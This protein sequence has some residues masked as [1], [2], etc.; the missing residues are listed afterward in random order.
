MWPFTKRSA[1]KRGPAGSR[2][3]RKAEKAHV[4]HVVG[5][6]SVGERAVPLV[7][8]QSRRARRVALNIDPVEDA[9]E[10]VLPRGVPLN[11]GLRFAEQK[12][13]WI[14][15]RL[16]LRPPKVAFEPGAVIPY[17]GIDHVIEHRPD[18]RAGVWRAESRVCVSGHA[19]FTS[20]RVQD[21][22][23]A[24]ALRELT[25]RS[26]EKAAQLG[27][28]VKH[29]HLRDPKG[30]WGSC[31]PD[32]AINYS[33]RLILAPELVLDYVV[34]HEVAH[35]IHNNH[36]VRF[37]RLVARLTPEM[38]ASRDWLSHH[39]DRLMRYG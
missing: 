36:G 16:A 33:W 10:L 4:P 27:R 37:W 29:V 25:E 7:A 22:L 28:R 3:A 26:H 17:L 2:P 24:E 1:I 21:W 6:V 8:R 20:R 9:V 30:R 38:E 13:G 14:Q 18:A 12:A 35:I 11:E 39:G 32:G 15:S 31:G 5:S 19:D 34:A 23:K